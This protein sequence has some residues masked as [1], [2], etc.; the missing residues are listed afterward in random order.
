MN[1][2]L[3]LIKIGI[4][5]NL[6]GYNALIW[7][8]EHPEVHG[9]DIYKECAKAMNDS[10]HNVERRIRHTLLHVHPKYMNKIMMGNKPKTITFIECLR[11]CI[12]NDI[13][14]EEA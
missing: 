13:F 5:P 3:L 7:A 4:T 8:L 1:I 10:A 12:N 2:K 9:C 11:V 14:S 6:K